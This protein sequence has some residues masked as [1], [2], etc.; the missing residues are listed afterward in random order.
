MPRG[1]SKVRREVK[2]PLITAFIVLLLAQPAYA[3]WDMDQLL[4]NMDD[5]NGLIGQFCGGAEQAGDY[6]NFDDSITSSISWV[7]AL[8]PS[9][10]RVAQRVGFTGVETL[11]GTA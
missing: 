11:G 10:S 1:L 2:K 6:I 3:Q 4:G 5:F 8:Q 9:I 7:C